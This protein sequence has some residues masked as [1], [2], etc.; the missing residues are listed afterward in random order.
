MN[1]KMA[2]NS[3]PLE[4]IVASNNAAL[5]KV[6]ASNLAALPE[7]FGDHLTL[8]QGFQGCTTTCTW[9]MH[10]SSS[11]GTETFAPTPLWQ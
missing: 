1:T 11:N 3:L 6:S 9:E 2:T 8:S 10:R 5:E 4:H 7:A